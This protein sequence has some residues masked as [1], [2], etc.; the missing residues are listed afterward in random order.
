MVTVVKST[1]M[2][3]SYRKK[4]VMVRNS[5]LLSVTIVAEAVNRKFCT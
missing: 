4:D 5:E 3:N 1:K 2:I